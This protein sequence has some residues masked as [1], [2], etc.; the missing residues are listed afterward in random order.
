MSKIDV[1]QRDKAS[2]EEVR[3]LKPEDKKNDFE[4]ESLGNK[5]LKDV[6]RQEAH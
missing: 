4:I 3:S 1:F 6:I 5:I 2:Q